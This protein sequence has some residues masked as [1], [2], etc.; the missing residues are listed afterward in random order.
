MNFERDK[1]LMSIRNGRR[2]F[3]IFLVVRLLI[4]VAIIFCAIFFGVKLV[5]AISNVSLKN[6]VEQV[7][8]G[9]NSH[10]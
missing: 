7:W 3:N 2:L 10:N 6:V 8:E 9:P 1:K 4:G 5:K